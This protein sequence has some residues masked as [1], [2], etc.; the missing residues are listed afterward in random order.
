[1]LFLE[2]PYLASDVQKCIVKKLKDA[3]IQFGP[4]IIEVRVAVASDRLPFGDGSFTVDPITFEPYFT[5]SKTGQIQ[6]AVRVAK[7]DRLVLPDCAETDSWIERGKEFGEK[8]DRLLREGLYPE[9]STYDAVW[10]LTYYFLS[11][12]ILSPSETTDF[13]MEWIR[14]KHNGYSNSINR[15]DLD[16]SDTKIRN[17]VNGWRPKNPAK[18]RRIFSRRGRQVSAT[19]VDQILQLFSK[20]DDQRRAFALLSY[21]KANAIL[22][23]SHQCAECLCQKNPALSV[24]KYWAELAD[25]EFWLCPIPYHR[26]TSL[27]KFSTRNVKA[28]LMLLASSFLVAKWRPANWLE[29]QCS[30]FFIAFKYTTETTEFASLDEALGARFSRSELIAKYGA[31]RARRIRAT[32]TQ[33]RTSA[34]TSDDQPEETKSPSAASVEVEAASSTAPKA[35]DHSARECLDAKPQEAK[36]RRMRKRKPLSAWKQI[37]L[38]KAS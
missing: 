36:I 15:G 25:C 4:A 34:T 11:A 29:E 38:A 6:Y 16:P 22:L 37:P 26:L 28:F 9:I 1:M 2:R 24:F 32:S 8:V 10:A 20:Y 3:K 14:H 33:P 12:R 17:A 30:I 18:T 35:L 31:Y 21:V 5:L 19:D 7:C 27:D 23:P 13:L